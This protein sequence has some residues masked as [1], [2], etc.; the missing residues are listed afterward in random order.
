M[1]KCVVAISLLLLRAHSAVK[2]FKP[3]PAVK[4]LAKWVDAPVPRLLNAHSASHPDKAFCVDS[5]GQETSVFADTL[6]QLEPLIKEQT[7][8]ANDYKSAIKDLCNFAGAANS[9]CEQAAS[10]MSG[11]NSYSNRIYDQIKSLAD[12]E[13]KCK[14]VWKYYLKQPENKG[15]QTDLSIITSETL[16]AI[17]D[18]AQGNIDQAVSGLQETRLMCAHEIALYT[19]LTYHLGMD[20]MELIG[21]TFP[22][23]KDHLQALNPYIMN[24]GET[25][26]NWNWH[27]APLYD[28]IK[29]FIV[30]PHY[31]ISHDFQVHRDLI[32]HPTDIA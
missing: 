32:I 17:H 20:P 2:Q 14:T 1:F 19:A 11:D 27:I 28:L 10:T 4:Q 16:K 26:T 6:T 5:T 18:L 25:K 3:A 29:G 8:N 31:E 12:A 7:V 22:E 21:L 13:S 30:P 24:E 23:A 15:G 9:D